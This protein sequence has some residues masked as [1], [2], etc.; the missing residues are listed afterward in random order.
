MKTKPLI[1]VI[2]II[3]YDND[4]TYF[5]LLSALNQNFKSFEIIV[6]NNVG[7]KITNK[8]ILNKIKSKKIRYFDLKKKKYV[9]ELRNFG[10]NKSKSQFISI[11]DSDDFFAKNHLSEA[12]KILKK[13]F[14][15]FYFT[16]YINFNLDNRKSDLRKTVTKLTLFDL[17]TFCPIGHSTVIFNKKFINRY[18]PIKYRHDLATWS[19]LLVLKKRDIYI[20]NKSKIIR[21]IHSKNLSK[22]KLKLLK[23][24]FI[25]YQKYFNLNIF[26]IIFYSLSLIIR[27]ALR[28]FNSNNVNNLFVKNLFKPLLD[29]LFTLD[30]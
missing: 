18:Y 3:G 4:L 11:L 12:Y 10:I 17:L 8:K 29:Y 7:K 30:K 16:S 1:S 9:Y 13:N 28:Y 6:I 21:T 5:S 15:K 20:N 26:Q 19:K 23:Y 27:H 2:F 14:F 22:N 24:Y 25:V